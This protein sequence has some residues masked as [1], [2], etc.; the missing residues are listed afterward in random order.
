MA[1][2]GHIIRDVLVKTKL[3]F[4]RENGSVL[5]VWLTSLGQLCQELSMVQEEL[6]CLAL[7]CAGGC[8]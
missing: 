2:H 1:A 3:F 7:I 6:K 4:P 5:N 8:S